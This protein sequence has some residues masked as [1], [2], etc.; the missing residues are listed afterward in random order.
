MRT[1]NKGFSANFFKRDIKITTTEK[2][3]KRHKKG[4]FS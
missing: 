1:F 4:T 3:Q 2:A